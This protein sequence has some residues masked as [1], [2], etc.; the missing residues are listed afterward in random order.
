MLFVQKIYIYGYACARLYC[1]CTCVYVRV[2]TSWRREQ[3]CS[4]MPSIFSPCLSTASMCV[5]VSVRARVW[6]FEVRRKGLSVAWYLSHGINGNGTRHS[7]VHVGHR[8]SCDRCN[9]SWGHV[10]ASLFTFAP[11]HDLRFHLLRRVVNMGNRVG[12]HHAC[13]QMRQ[14]KH[15]ST[16]SW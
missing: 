14:S 16:H 6:A 3:I 4:S 1:N 10:Y 7:D 13:R 9:A 15:E 2:R 8:H 12:V 5:C 11:V